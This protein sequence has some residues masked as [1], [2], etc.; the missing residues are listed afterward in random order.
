MAIID[1]YSEEE[2]RQMV[3]ESKSFRE[4]SIKIGYT[5]T[6]RTNDT[7]RK[8]LEKYSIS[9]EHFSA[10]GKN[11]IKRSEQNVF[12][13]NSTATQA[14]LRR[15]Y[16]KGN[17]SEYK[18]SICGLPPVW[19]G[20]DLTLTLDHINGCN[21]DNRLENLRWICPN[22][23]RQ[24]DTFAGKKSQAHQNYITKQAEEQKCFCKN[25]G[26]PISNGSE[27]CISCYA[28]SRR[29]VERPSQEVLREELIASNFAAVGRKYGV[30]DNTIRKWCK[31][32]GMSTRAADYK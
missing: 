4:L 11:S 27:L 21:K 15:W 26:K 14:V 7:I 1:K 2:L 30:A 20:K 10:C 17:Y 22:C 19:N 8:R 6:G 5:P 28:K 16:I 18:C 25:Y 3:A 31:A 24:L 23:D 29:I 13:E 9:T 32:Y 12:C